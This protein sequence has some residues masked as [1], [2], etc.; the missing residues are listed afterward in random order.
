MA[1]LS[2][3][4]HQGRPFQFK[5]WHIFIAVTVIAAVLAVFAIEPGVSV[6][7]ASQADGTLS[8]N[9]SKNFKVNNIRGV[10]LFA[11]DPNV[12]LWQVTSRF[13]RND[14]AGVAFVLH[15]GEPSDGGRLSRRLEP[16]EEFFVSVVYQFD[17][18]IPPAPC[19]ATK[20][21]RYKLTADGRPQY[22]DASP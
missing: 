7:V 10:F 6:K 17:T 5:L 4:R 12:P 8:A 21:F 11:D 22:L 9:V 18:T 14:L 3:S 19:T 15:P 20:N 13:G 1:I 2:A 16:G